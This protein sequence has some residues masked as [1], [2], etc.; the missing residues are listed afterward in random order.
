MIRT[1]LRVLLFVSMY[2]QM[3]QQKMYQQKI[4][5]PESHIKPSN[6]KWQE[7][8]FSQMYIL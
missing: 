2:Q 8:L 4:P 1:A 7:N 3:Y 6:I 5:R